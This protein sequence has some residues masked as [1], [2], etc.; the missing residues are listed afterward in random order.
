M[1][2]DELEL[3]DLDALV[4]PVGRV[5]FQQTRFDVL[6]I[7]GRGADLLQQI[8]IGRND[9]TSQRSWLSIARS[10]I[11]DCIPTMTVEQVQ[12]LSIE[13]V[14]AVIGIATKQADKVRRF[15]GAMEGNVLVPDITPTIPDTP[16]QPSTVPLVPS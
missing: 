12:A 10:I 15:V 4:R 6:P 3:I 2:D 14:T 13:Q 1:S 8:A 7:N 9:P 16:G 5:T 11:T